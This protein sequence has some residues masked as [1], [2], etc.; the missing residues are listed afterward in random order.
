MKRYFANVLSCRPLTEG[1][2]P[3]YELMLTKPKDFDYRQGQFVGFIMAHN[4]KEIIRWYS[5]ASH[6]SQDELRF[7]IKFVPGGFMSGKLKFFSEGDPIE[8]TEARGNLMLPEEPTIAIVTGT[9]I[10]PIMSLI[11]NKDRL[12]LHVIWGIRDKEYAIRGDEI[13]KS[14]TMRGGK[15]TPCYSKPAQGNG[16][17][18]GDVVSLLPSLKDYHFILVGN[19]DMVREQRKYLLNV[20]VENSR[21]Q[22]EIFAPGMPV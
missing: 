16:R 22:A 21:I 20:G 2:M 6:P 4:N 11:A 7:W 8:L 13:H 3:V 19:P 18:V 5:F 12:S 15:L 17:H 10:A 9:G 1:T 14:V